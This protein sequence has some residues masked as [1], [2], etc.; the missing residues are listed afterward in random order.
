[1]APA[2]GT[3]ALGPADG[4]L[5]V[6]TGKGGAA[7]RAGHNLRIEVQRWGATVALAED[8]AQ[9]ALELTADSGSL[10]VVEG[11]GGMNSLDD[12][13]R[14]GIT[15]TINDEVLKGT[16]IAFRS[17]S[18]SGSDGRLSVQGDL[19]LAG[20]INPITFELAVADDGRITGT[21]IVKQ[22]AW[23]MKPYSAL[24]GTLKVSDEVEVSIDATLGDPQ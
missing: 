19:E 17:T 20:G 11:T 13:D 3:Y 8:P 12:D 2:P 10:Q 24:F 21:A 1:M 6:R 22:T 7:A 15:Q 14:A 5:S 9:T 16:A 4:H 18:V 23:G